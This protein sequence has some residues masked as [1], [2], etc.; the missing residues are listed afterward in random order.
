MGIIG[1]NAAAQ[2]LRATGAFLERVISETPYSLPEEIRRRAYEIYLGRGKDP[3]HEIED[4]RQAER[5][6]T[7]DRSKAHSK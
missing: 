4:W 1:F 7:A 2:A 3:G 5:E 6:L